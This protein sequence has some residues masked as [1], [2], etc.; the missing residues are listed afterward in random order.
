VT[1]YLALTTR[2]TVDYVAVKAVPFGLGMS[3]GGKHVWLFSKGDVYES[4]WDR[5]PA[6]NLYTTVPLE[7]FIWLSGIVVVPPGKKHLLTM[8]KVV[9]P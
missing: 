1:P 8:S 3:R 5:E 7:Q 6:G 4:H 2:N 9:C